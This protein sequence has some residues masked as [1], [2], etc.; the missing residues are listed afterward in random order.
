[1]E[2]V[3]DGLAMNLDGC[4]IGLTTHVFEDESRDAG[5]QGCAG[6]LMHQ[7]DLIRQCAAH[8]EPQDEKFVVPGYVAGTHGKGEFAPGHPGVK[9]RGFLVDHVLHRDTRV[10]TREF[11]GCK[12]TFVIIEACKHDAVLIPH[13]AC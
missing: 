11:N 7:P 8:D 12:F 3:A 9:L 1:M 4:S 2:F 5:R 6:L 13:A 10:P